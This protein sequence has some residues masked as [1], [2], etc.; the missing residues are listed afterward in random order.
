VLAV[1]SKVA[2]LDNPK[3][4]QA[5][6]FA[7]NRQAIIASIWRGQG[8]VPNGPVAFGDAVGYDP[9]RPGLACDPDRARQLLQEGGYAG[10]PVVLESTQG[11]LQSDYEMAQV[12]TSAWSG[13]GVNAQ[14]Q[15]IDPATRAQK[16]RDRSFRGLF[17]SDPASTLQDP[18]GMMWRL[19]GPGGAQDYWRD[20]EFDRLGNEAR[21][22]LDGELRAR[23]YARMVDLALE[24]LPWIPVLQPIESYGVRNGVT[25]KAMPNGIIQL[26]REVLRLDQ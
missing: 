24:N 20:A 26:R 22:S 14:L 5:L 23:D 8:L 10:E 4:K 12:I 18:D 11:Q 13:I 19:L 9:A 21:F 3:I 15:V 16:V 2:P 25:W 6:S 7:I 17:W 1:N